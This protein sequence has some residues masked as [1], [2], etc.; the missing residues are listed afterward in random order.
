M[1]I[2]IV[3]KSTKEQ[4]RVLAR[5]LANRL[6]SYGAV[7]WTED[8]VPPDAGARPDVVV[9]L[10]G[11]GTILRAARQYGP[12]E[13][14]ILGV[15]LG[16]VG[17]LAELRAEDLDQYLPRLLARDYTVQE[18]LMLK[19]TIMPAGGSPVSYLGLNDA[20]LRAETAR[21]VEISV[22]I[23]GEPL[24]LF[25]GDGLIVATPTGST[26]YSLAAGGP[27]ILTEVE[28]LLLTPINSFSLSSC[29]LVM[30]ADSVIRMQVTGLRK[31]G[32][33]VDGQVEVSMEPG[34][35]VEITRA[36]TVARLV[37]MK[38]KTLAEA[39]GARLRRGE[40]S[41]A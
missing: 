30:P 27:V 24:G 19:V 23:N 28:A 21:V 5:D 18:R 20:V 22:E 7:A 10:G 2:K 25:R 17:F 4:A 35:M 41:L 37:K 31:A 16:Q 6:R 1:N 33:T 13:I 26:G 40:G 38:D 11:D 29:P 8:E 15:N 9:I 3:F 14:P 34:E 39:L 36:D 12:Q 32:L